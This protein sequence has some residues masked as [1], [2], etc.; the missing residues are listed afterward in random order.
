MKM[1]LLYK[2]IPFLSDTFVYHETEG[3]QR[4][5][6]NEDPPKERYGNGSAGGD[7]IVVSRLDRPAGTDARAVAESFQLFAAGVVAAAR[8]G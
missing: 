5:H 2:P 8:R 1:Y 4:Y 3:F 6:Q 7:G